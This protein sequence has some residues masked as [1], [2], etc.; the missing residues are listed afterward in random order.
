[1]RIIL[2]QKWSFRWDKMIWTIFLLQRRISWKEFIL[3]RPD[4]QAFSSLEDLKSLGSN[5]SWLLRLLLIISCLK[6][7]R[8]WLLLE[9]Q[10]SWPFKTLEKQLKAIFL[11]FSIEFF[12]LFTRLKWYLKLLEKGSFLI[13]ELTYEMHGIFSILLLLWVLILNS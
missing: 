7:Y 2:I 11:T 3:I 10:Y 1:M 4:V 5:L 13:K 8:L 6:Q 9:T 12:L